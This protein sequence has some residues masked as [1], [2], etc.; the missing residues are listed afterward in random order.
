VAL[1]LAAADEPDRVPS[2]ADFVALARV[3]FFVF[4]VLLFP[5]LH[6]GASM[7]PADYVDLIAY[8]L[9]RTTSGRAKRVIFNLP[10]GHMK[11]LLV[12]ILYTAWRLGVNPSEKIICI[13][14]GDDLTHDLSRKARLVMQSD[15]YK[16]IF[17]GTVLDKKAEDS[18]TT[19]KGG[20]RYATAVGSDIAGFRADLIVIDDPMQPDEIAS[21]PAKQ[22]L[23][24]WYYGNVAQR[25]LDQSKGVI[26]LVM[27]RL[28]P[29][30]LTATFVEEGGWSH[31]PLPL[32]AVAKQHYCTSDRRHNLLLRAPGDILNPNWM[33]RETADN[34]RKRLPPHIF[35]AQY[36][37]NPQF[38]G[39]GMCTIDRLARYRDEPPFELIIHSWDLAATKGGGDWTV[40]A[41]FGLA[42]DSNG[43]DILYFLAVIRMRVELPDVRAMIVEQDKLDKPALIVMDGNGIGLNVFQ[44]LTDRGRPGGPLKHILP[45]GNLNKARTADLKVRQF[46]PT[47]QH[48]YDGLI[49]IPNSMPGL[50]ILLAELAAF[51]DGKHDDQ[52]DAVSVVGANLKYLIHKAR[53]F[54]EQ[55]G[56]WAPAQKAALAQAQRNQPV[57]PRRP[58]RFVGGYGCNDDVDDE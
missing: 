27:H 2:Q 46:H 42:K 26:I 24:D 50:E 33:S 32:I 48:L 54:A 8:V 41:K 29:D 49:L 10:P 13:S 39:S 52:V 11:S 44:D 18:I 38:G 56:L 21:E 9:M 16:S 40:C 57:A 36:Q 51:P 6:G 25:L 28:A 1:A 43:R 4:A 55:Y 3:D 22:K 58:R 34:F 14:Y 37:Q 47:M 45:S 12:S 5:V 15:L 23:R 7:T 31:I 53:F 17:P 35:E 20:Q 30:D 19:T